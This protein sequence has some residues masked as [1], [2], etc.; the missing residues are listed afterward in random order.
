VFNL[1]QLEKVAA[2]NLVAFIKTI[3]LFSP[4]VPPTITVP[5]HS[6]SAQEGSNVDLRCVAVGIPPPSLHWE[7]GGAVVGN[8]STLTIGT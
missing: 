8:G 5:P 1:G 4:T 6:S 3:N 2:L 7:F